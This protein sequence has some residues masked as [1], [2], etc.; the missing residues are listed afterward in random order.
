MRHLVKEQGLEGAIEVD[1]A[2][3]GG[4]HIGEAPDSRARAA[5][6]RRGIEISGHARQVTRADFAR[7]DYVLGM[8]GEN[9]ANLKRLAPQNCSA[10]LALLRSFDPSA[11]AG[12]TSC[13]PFVDAI[14]C[15][16]S[17]A[18]AGYY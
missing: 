1:S 18:A 17:V 10:H 16:M 4:Y 2:G 12:A 7:F 11:P 5:G 14:E 6:R 8:D 13:S 3:T 9:L 15:S